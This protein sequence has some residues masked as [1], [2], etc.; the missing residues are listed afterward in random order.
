M[1]KKGY[2][3][4]YFAKNVDKILSSRY[5]QELFDSTRQI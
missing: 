4:S 2:G 5:S 3:F 1:S